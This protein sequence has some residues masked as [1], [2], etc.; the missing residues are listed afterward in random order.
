MKTFLKILNGFFVFLGVVFFIIILA[1]TYFFWKDPFNLRPIISDLA[2]I[3]KNIDS[4]ETDKHPLLSP[5]QEI[6]LKALGVDPAK[7]PTEI[8]P[9]LEKCLAEKLG[10]ER[11]AEIKKTGT[12]SATDILTGK[13][14]LNQ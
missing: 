1:L 5:S 7:L 8:T 6:A 10:A 12:P 2:G 4:A 14:C 13:D 9:E 11:M 3:S